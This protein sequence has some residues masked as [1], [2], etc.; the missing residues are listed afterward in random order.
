LD[1]VELDSQSCRG[2]HG[3]GGR[4]AC[5]VGY[6]RMEEDP[7]VGFDPAGGSRRL[8]TTEPASDRDPGAFTVPPGSPIERMRLSPAQALAKTDARP[9]LAIRAQVPFRGGVRQA[10]VDRIAAHGAGQLGD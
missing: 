2:D 9:R 3:Q 1:L 6:A 7:S 5:D 8:S 10:Q 4:R